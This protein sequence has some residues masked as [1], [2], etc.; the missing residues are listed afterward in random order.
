MG[1]GGGVWREPVTDHVISG[2]MRGA[3]KE[4]L[5]RW[6]R[7]TDMVT[8]RLNRPSGANS[9]KNLCTMQVC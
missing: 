9:V 1:K 5:N 4:N 3:A 6:R 2:P 8:L 7:Q